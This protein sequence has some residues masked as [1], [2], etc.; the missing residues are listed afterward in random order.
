MVIF[1][2]L[3]YSERRSQLGPVVCL[4][5]LLVAVPAG[6]VAGPAQGVPGR[7]GEHGRGDQGL[8]RARQE[9][10]RRHPGVRVQQ[11]RRIRTVKSA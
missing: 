8:H 2:S 7:R 4:E 5:Q 9:G 6:R 1:G 10:Q 11:V 3:F